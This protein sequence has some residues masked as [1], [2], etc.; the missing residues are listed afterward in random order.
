MF[1]GTFMAICHG[2]ALPSLMLIFGDLTN[3][4]INQAVSREL[5]NSLLDSDSV[6]CSFRLASSG[7]Y[8]VSDTISSD[9]SLEITSTTTFENVLTQC[10]SSEAECLDNDDFTDEINMQILSFVGIG[11]GVFIAANLQIALFQIACERQTHKIQL[12][13]YRAILRQNIGWFD[14]N[15]SGELASRLTE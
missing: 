5:Y 1:V 14:A 3:S 15:P 2:A 7:L 13:F 9:C 4:F 6:N 8:N 10:F 12:K 11:V